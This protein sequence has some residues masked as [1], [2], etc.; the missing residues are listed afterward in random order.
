MRENY[1]MIGVVIIGLCAATVVYLAISA[2]IGRN[3][4]PRTR[5]RRPRHVDLSM[6][7]MTWKSTDTGAWMAP[8]RT[9]GTRT[10]HRM[11]ATF[12]DRGLLLVK[13]A[14]RRALRLRQALAKGE[15]S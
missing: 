1:L 15:R 5:S 12:R 9:G 4:R 11:R 3:P 10:E 6:W 2:L 8:L 13:R 14:G 7:H